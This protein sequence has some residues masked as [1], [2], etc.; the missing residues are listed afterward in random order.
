[1]IDVLKCQM[2]EKICNK[3]YDNLCDDFIE[4]E[5]TNKW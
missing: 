2:N 1:M 3:K 4:K 5:N